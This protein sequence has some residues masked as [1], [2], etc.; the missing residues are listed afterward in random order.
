MVDKISLLDLAST[1][2]ELKKLEFENT[3]YS[4]N[5]KEAFD[6]ISQKSENWNCT[7]CSSVKPN[8]IIEGSNFLLIC[9]ECLSKEINIE[10]YSEYKK[11][12]V[13]N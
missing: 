4:K 8:V 5:A 9:G 6:Q 13:L 1:L 11:S 2:A 10:N 7:K 3:K 12:K